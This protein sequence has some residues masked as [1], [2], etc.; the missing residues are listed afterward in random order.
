MYGLAG[1]EREQCLA[2]YHRQANL[3]LTES[4]LDCGDTYR[5][6]CAR[7]FLEGS[8]QGSQRRAQWSWVLKD[9]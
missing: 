6:A 7:L 8:E 4:L 2:G 9:E 3:N 5:E 1:Q